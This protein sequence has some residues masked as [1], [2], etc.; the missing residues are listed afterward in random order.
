[1]VFMVTQPVLREVW[2]GAFRDRVV[3]HWEHLRYRSVLERYFVYAGDRSMNCRKGYG[4]LRAV[5]TFQRSLYDY[6]EG[7]TRDD[8]YIV[9]GDFANFFMSID[10]ELLWS[11]LSELMEKVYKGSDRA[12]LLYMMRT[13][14]F[15]RCQ[16]DYFRRS[17]EG[18]WA[19][20]PA[21]KSLFH[22]NGLP[23]GNL[24]S[25]NWANFLGAVATIYAVNELR[26]DGFLI[27]VD[28]WRG[29][30]RT[31][32]EGRRVIE[33]FRRYLADELHIT[34]H[35]D[36]V[37]LQ[38]YTKGTKLVG[39][40]IKPP[41]ARR[42]NGVL[43]KWLERG[44]DRRVLS[45]RK[46]VKYLMAGLSR[47]GGER[48]ERGRVYISNRTRGRFIE[49][50][51]RYKERAER[52]DEAGRVKM[53]EELRGSVNSYLGMMLHFDSYKLRRGIVEE[54]VVPVWGRYVYFEEEYKVMKIRKAYDEKFLLRHRLKRHE[55]AAE[56]IRPKNKVAG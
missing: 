4:V 49:A 35:P 34:L 20:L 2:A 16:D 33:E 45:R 5:R 15:H 22:M 29:L 17:P 40:V 52:A 54:W 26:L 21:R 1:M 46:F 19:G 12:A 27:F 28:D 41:S 10:K 23:I 47:K 51:R 36:K 7:Y 42:G 9:G 3:H 31:R 50:M 14:M 38:H 39:A 11:L 13:T 8:C 56:F 43:R 53:L 55:Y 37:Y 44:V 25:Q 6:T 24:P 48:R 32:D 18:M 30:V